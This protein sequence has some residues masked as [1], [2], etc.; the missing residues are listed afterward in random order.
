MTGGESRNRIPIAVA[1][2]LPVSASAGV[3]LFAEPQEEPL[4]ITH[5]SGYDGTGGAL[6]VS[7]CIDETSESISEIEIP[8]QNTIFRWNE[9]KVASPN[10]F[11]GSDNNIPSGEL[12][13][14]SVMLHEM[15]HCVGLAHPNAASESGLGEPEANST[16]ALVGEDGM[17]NTDA[18]SDGIVGSADDVRGDD[19]NLHWVEIGQNNPFQMPSTIDG[20]TMSVELADL[21]VGDN[22]PA[23]ADRNVGADL[24]FDDSEAVMQQNTL[25]NEAQR[26]LGADDVTTLR[27]GM[28]GLDRQQGTADDYEPVLGFEG[29]QP[30]DSDSCDVVVKVAGDGIGN[31]QVSALFLPGEHLAITRGTI[32]I[33]STSNF[34]WFFNQEPAFEV[35][36]VDGFE[37][38]Q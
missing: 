13:F 6:E 33:G 1:F 30:A 32:T 29:V 35:I 7:V 24:G 11:F 9:R 37:S 10:L 8:V 15:G 4:L 3:F 36:F 12:D 28:S 38:T 31:C 34:D 2:L 17:L 22:F 26:T 18:G 21:P 19:V 25:L 16:K 23:N 20:S 27:L 5:P 14:E